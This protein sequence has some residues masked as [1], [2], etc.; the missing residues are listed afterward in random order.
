MHLISSLA[1]RFGGPSK[2]CVE[3]AE[4][5]AKLGHDVTIYTT[6]IDGTNDLNVP[7]DK[8]IRR[9]GVT[10]KYFQVNSPRFW[11][12]SL[13]MA[14][15]LKNDIPK[16]DLVHMHSLYLFHNLVGGYYCRKYNTPYIIRIH[17]TLDPFLYNRHRWRKTIIERLYENKNLKHASAIHYT[18]QEEKIL[19]ETH[20][21]ASPGIVV[22]NGLDISMYNALPK[23][24]MFRELYPETI[25]KQIILFFSRL[26]FKKGLDILTPAFIELA[27]QNKDY[28]L[29]LA[30]PDNEGLGNWVKEQIK[31][32]G[33][34]IYGKNTRVT[35]TG[36][37]TGKKKLAVLNDANVFALPSYSENFGIAVIEAMLC[38]LPVII[39]NKVNIWRDIKEDNAGLIGPCDVKWFRNSIKKLLADK[40]LCNKLSKAGIQSVKKR[41]D[42][43]KIAISLSKHYQNIVKNYNKRSD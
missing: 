24:G 35:I 37:L 20:C 27:K 41:Y 28:H 1:T 40:A 10:Y 25:G 26:N 4:A 18:T 7:T 29:V 36:M 11:R 3:M 8:F 17:G 14:K 13:S 9:N 15:A 21:F 30:G 23:K 16:F 39:S 2:A 12:P 42:W 22:P 38:G 19:A 34:A 6:N 31:N 43:N 32:A 5:T 33:L